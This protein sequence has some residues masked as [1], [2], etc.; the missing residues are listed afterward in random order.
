MLYADKAALENRTK[1]RL[2]AIRERELELYTRNCR[3][4]G[5]VTALMS[6]IAFSSIIY[7]KMA[8]FQT[9]G[10][11]WQALYLVGNTSTMCL[12]LQA[13]AGTTILTMLG[14]GRALRGPD[15]SM[16]E[17]VDGLAAEFVQVSAIFHRSVNFFL[18]T[19]LVHAWGPLA[20]HWLASV[21]LTAVVWYAYRT[22]RERSNL[23]HNDFART[24]TI[25]GAFFHETHLDPHGATVATASETAAK[26]LGASYAGTSGNTQRAYAEQQQ[27]QHAERLLA[28]SRARSDAPEFRSGTRGAGFAHVPGS[29]AGGSGEPVL[30]ADSAPPLPPGFGQQRSY[31]PTPGQQGGQARKPAAPAQRKLNRQS[32]RYDGFRML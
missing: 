14:P 28:A 3:T 20:R 27:R 22:V 13:V 1:L 18:F 25:S 19:V 24:E 26:L 5:T 23:A 10:W 2:I 15:G 11:V 7:T 4:V 9:A 30:M 16:H 32:T 17:T 12:G 6:G 31:V 8:Y 21:V 29:G